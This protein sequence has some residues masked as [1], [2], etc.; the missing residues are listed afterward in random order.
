MCRSTTESLRFDERLIFR[1]VV[2]V[3][4]VGYDSRRVIEL[5]RQFLEYLTG[6]SSASC[7][8][9]HVN[10]IYLA[11]RVLSRVLSSIIEWS[12]RVSSRRKTN[13]PRRDVRVSLRWL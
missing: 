1:D 10:L 8:L 4:R 2:Y 13:I 6:L 7:C 3:R 12:N 5:F 9:M 11:I